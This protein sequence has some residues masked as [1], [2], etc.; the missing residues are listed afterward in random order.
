MVQLSWP[1]SRLVD[2][3]GLRP[4]VILVKRRFRR[5]DSTSKLVNVA[6]TDDEENSKSSVLE[7]SEV[8]TP[9]P[10][11]ASQKGDAVTDSK[12]CQ[13]AK[14]IASLI[15]NPSTLRPKQNLQSSPAKKSKP[16]C[17]TRNTNVK[18]SAATPLVAQEDQ[19]IKRQK[20]ER[21]KSRQLKP[22]TADPHLV[23]MASSIGDV[24]ERLI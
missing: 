20:L 12:N 10:V 17:V 23:G 3:S 8:S 9:K 13:T 14:K 7:G 4:H 1:E 15:K 5:S 6:L 24:M 22:I 21:G 16:E 18:D 19:A 11:M 2:P